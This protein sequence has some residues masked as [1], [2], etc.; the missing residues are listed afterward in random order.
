[1]AEIISM[2]GI[3]SVEVQQF[4]VCPLELSHFIRHDQ[5]KALGVYWSVFDRPSQRFADQISSLQVLSR[6]D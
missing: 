5:K 2:V 4:T 6:F 1:M 3:I